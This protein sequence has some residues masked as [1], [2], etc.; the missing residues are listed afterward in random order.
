MEG[1][2]V[3]KKLKNY[4]KNKTFSI[5]LSVMLVIAEIFGGIYIAGITNYNYGKKLEQIQL[6]SKVAEHKIDV[7]TEL[8]SVIQEPILIFKTAPSE[9]AKSINGY[10]GAVDSCCTI[11][12]DHETFGEWVTKFHQFTSE[13]RF[14]FDEKI[15]LYITQIYLYDQKLEEILSNIPEDEAWQVGV[16]LHSEIAGM[17]QTLSQLLQEYLNDGVYDLSKTDVNSYSIVGELPPQ[18]DIVRY[19]NDILNYFN[20]N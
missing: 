14:L 20:N 9:L 5:T 12:K 2:I 10:E 1:G 13:N 7:A 15:N 8:L 18:S 16:V 6:K 17:Y 11:L 4:L 19:E 3:F